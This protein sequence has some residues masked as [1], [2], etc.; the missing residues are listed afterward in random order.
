MDLRDKILAIEE[1]LCEIRDHIL[2]RDRDRCA[3]IVL[4]PAIL[5][6]VVG[7][8]DRE[9]CSM[10]FLECSPNNLFVS[11]GCFLGKGNSFDVVRVLDRRVFEELLGNGFHLDVLNNYPFI[12]APDL[13]KIFIKELAR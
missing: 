7:D 10:D 4:P 11:D 1:L 12:M 5:S 3:Y 8:F 13:M 9:V 2:T 6:C